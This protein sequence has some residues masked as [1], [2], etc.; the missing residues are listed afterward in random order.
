MFFFFFFFFL[1]V[2]YEEIKNYVNTSS[3]LE[4]MSVLQ[5]L[6]AKKNKN[7]FSVFFFFFFFFCKIFLY[8]IE[9]IK[10]IQN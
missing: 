8:S 4:C 1:F 9:M 10:M 7:I 6:G 3:Y 2:S 5:F